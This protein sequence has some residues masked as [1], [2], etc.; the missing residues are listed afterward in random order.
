MEINS[1][2]LVCRERASPPFKEGTK[3]PDI[4]G[5]PCLRD[6]SRLKDREDM[7][8]SSALQSRIDRYETIF[9]AKIFRWPAEG[10]GM[11]LL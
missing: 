11:S 5:S 10:C 8:F 4:I 6:I 3:P 2:A 1:E 9:E 7:A